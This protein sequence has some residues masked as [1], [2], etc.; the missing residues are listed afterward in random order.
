M[1]GQAQLQT[2]PIT[3]RQKFIVGHFDGH[4]VA[5]TVAY[6]RTNNVSVDNI[7][8]RFPDTGP[9]KITDFIDTFFPT[10]V[11]YDVI[12]ID[13]PVNLKNPRAWV[14]AVNRLASNTN[15]VI[16]DH[17]ETDVQYAS[18]IL[19]RMIIF[20]NATRMA[21]VLSDENN[22]MLAYI[23][24]IADRDSSILNVMDRSEVE[25]LMPLA[26]V[27]DVLVRQDTLQV[28]RNLITATDPVQW[29][30]LQ[31]Q[32][33]SYP[34]A[35]FASSVE[36]LRRGYNTLLIDMTKLPQN[37]GGWSWKIMEQ[38]AY[39]HN[40]DYVVAIN[41][42]MDRQVNQTVPAVQVIRYWLSQR[43][44]PRPQL[45]PIMGRQTIGHDDAFSVRA[46]DANDARQLAEQ[47]FN[48]LE[49]LTPRVTHLINDSNVAEAVRADFNAILQ[50]LTR[51]LEQQN[52]MYQEY[53]ELKKQQV[54]LLRR[55]ADTRTRAD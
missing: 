12:M 14:D 17:H 21:E 25:R 6:A 42:V 29:L 41:Q 39:V 8:V 38:V 33:V 26:N 47:I 51:I 22:R 19:G 2:L 7:Y 28:V 48:G 37:A 53:L 50:T 18:Q 3:T 20:P 10:L 44:S 1:I 46:L 49:T 52:R 32:S 24:V 9:E 15:V 36:I 31:S 43:P 23:G 45:Q 30:R 54:E 11:K 40:V 4:G 16:Y 27:L 5:T 55:T 34:P 35:Q 13:I